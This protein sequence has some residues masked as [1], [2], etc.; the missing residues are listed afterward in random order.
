ME[1]SVDDPT[2]DVRLTDLDELLYRQIHPNWVRTG[3][4]TSQLFR[5]TGKDEGQLSVARSTL[6]SAETAFNRWIARGFESVGVWGVLVREVEANELAAFDGPAAEKAEE[7][8]HG[9]VD[10]DA[11]ARKL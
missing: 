6:T 5:P 10:F 11:L 2:V 1:L 3:E 9:Y 8:G 7:P 4:P